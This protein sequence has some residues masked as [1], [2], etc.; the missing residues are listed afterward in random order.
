MQE[1]VVPRSIKA[2]AAFLYFFLTYLRRFL[3]APTVHFFLR[4]AL[5]ESVFPNSVALKDF[6]KTY[7]PCSNNGNLKVG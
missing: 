1:F 4:D 6:K 5:L 7:E 3:E 2:S